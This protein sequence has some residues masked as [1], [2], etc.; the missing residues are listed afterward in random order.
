MLVIESKLFDGS[1]EEVKMTVCTAYS[2]V[3]LLWEA[4]RQWGIG[5]LKE[6]DDPDAYVEHMI[7]EAH[8]IGSG[9]EIGL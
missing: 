8:E 3:K 2:D 4:A 1:G 5:R 7:Y 6:I 9:D